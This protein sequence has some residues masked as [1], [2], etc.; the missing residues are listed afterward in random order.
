MPKSLNISN[1]SLVQSLSSFKPQGRDKALL[2]P[3][4]LPYTYPKNIELGVG[5]QNALHQLAS[6]NHGLW[7]LL[8]FI[9]LQAAVTLC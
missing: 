2:L 8:T 4:E 7:R 5:W 3:G 1:P 6:M 9:E